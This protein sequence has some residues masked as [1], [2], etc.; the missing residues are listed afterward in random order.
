MT[1]YYDGLSNSI[2]FYH[3]FK[4]KWQKTPIQLLYLE[5]N[6]TLGIQC[7]Y[8]KAYFLQLIYSGTVLPHSHKDLI[9]NILQMAELVSACLSTILPLSS[10]GRVR[11]FK[12]IWFSLVFYKLRMAFFAMKKHYVTI[13]TQKFNFVEWAPCPSSS[14][15]YARTHRQGERFFFRNNP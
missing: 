7:L 4:R 14:A 8:Q 5:K 10:P 1:W 15:N 11:R 2:V 13:L 12:N 9:R 3:R 6:G